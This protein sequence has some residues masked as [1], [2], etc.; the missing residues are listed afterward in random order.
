MF[1]DDTTLCCVGKDIEE[2]IDMMN[3]AAKELFSW[4]KKNQLTVHTG[5][6]GYDYITYRFHWTT[7]TCLVRNFHHK[8][9]YTQH[10]PRNN[11]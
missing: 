10:L 2:V 8:L 6:T 1:A 5:K 7:E 4:C 9:C 11:N 3:Q